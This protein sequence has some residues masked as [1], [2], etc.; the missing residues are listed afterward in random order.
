[1]VKLEKPQTEIMLSDREFL[2]DNKLANISTGVFPRTFL[3]APNNG[4]GNWNNKIHNIEYCSYFL[5]TAYSK[6]LKMS[7][8][9]Y[10]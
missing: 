10:N 2:L 4:S 3:A 8:I 5:I 9:Y 7:L 1:M 6:L